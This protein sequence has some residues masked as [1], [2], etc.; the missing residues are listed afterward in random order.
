MLP[1]NFFSFSFIFSLLVSSGFAADAQTWDPIYEK[2]KPSIPL[3]IS[4]SGICSGALIEKDLILTAAHCVYALRP[5]SVTWADR[6]G[7]YESGTAVA[8]DEEA[9]LALVRIQ[10][11]DRLPLPLVAKDYSLKVGQIIA[12]VGHPTSPSMKKKDPG[13]YNVDET[14]LLS[15]GI[16]SGISESDYITDMSVSPGNSGGPAFN[17]AGQIVGVVSRKRIGI[18]VGNIG[19][20][21]RNSEIQ[22]LKDKLNESKSTGLPWYKAHTSFHLDLSWAGHNFIKETPANHSYIFSVGAVLDIFDRLRLEYETNFDDSP[23]LYSYSLGYNF[24]WD[25][26]NRT[27]FVLTPSVENLNFSWK[28]TGTTTEKTATGYGLNLAWSYFPL[29][30]K[31]INYSVDSKAYTV[32]SMQLPLM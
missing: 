22:A 27:N 13:F 7:A 5:V 28:V 3:L 6:I 2:V 29:R 12:T 32:V 9:D 8:M 18:G 10:P 14:Y 24:S 11:S 30:F 23:N 16:V 19:Y 25:L 4:K 20:V 21:V 1:K 31:I 26:P 17:Q 15:T